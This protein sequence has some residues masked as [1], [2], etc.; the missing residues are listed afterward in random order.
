[1]TSD[2]TDLQTKPLEQLELLRDYQREWLEHLVQ[3]FGDPAVTRRLEQLQQLYE[4]VEK[5][6]VGKPPQKHR[7]EERLP[8]EEKQ[9]SNRPDM[10][11]GHEGGRY[12]LNIAGVRRLSV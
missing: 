7:Y 9:R 11:N 8:S 4:D 12:P 2:Y 6:R 5:R 10:E 3:V 1:M